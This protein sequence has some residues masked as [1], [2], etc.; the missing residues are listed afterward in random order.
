MSFRCV[1]DSKGGY[2]KF[3]EPIRDKEQIKKVKQVLKQSNQRN[4]LLFVLGINSGLRI[5][6]ILKLKVKDVKNKK[7]IEIK[8]QKTKKYK[9]FPITKTLKLCI[10]KYINNKLSEDWLFES[11]R[12]S[13]PITRVQAYRIICNACNN[14]GINLNIGTHTLRKTFGYHFYQEKKDIVILQKIFNHSTPDITLRYIG[15]NQD[16]I[17]LNLMTFSL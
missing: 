10:D 11:K 1:I 14:A 17:D 9:K 16:I 4:Y 6:D 7:C 5:S 8:E 13:Q 3:V 15:I 12:G 2:M